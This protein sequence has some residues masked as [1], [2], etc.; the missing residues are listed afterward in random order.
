MIITSLDEYQQAARQTAIYPEQAALAY[1]ALGLNGEAGEA[2]DHIKKAIRDNDGR[3][4]AARETA[5]LR[6]LGDVLWYVAMMADEL[7][8][9]LS[10]VARMNIDKLALRKAAGTIGGS[11]DER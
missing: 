5:I 11:G 7:G 8:R 3:L 1:L 9:D 2:A 4:D 6:E 10:T